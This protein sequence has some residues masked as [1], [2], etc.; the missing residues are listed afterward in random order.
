MRRFFIGALCLVTG[1][2]PITRNGK[3]Y[4]LVLGVGVI[5]VSQTNEVTVVRANS[6]GI[7][8]GDGRFNVGLSSVY[9]AHIPT[10]ANVVLEVK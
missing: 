1:C 5:R 10:N 7:Y 2:V 4:H 9:S 6:L 3:T 8:G